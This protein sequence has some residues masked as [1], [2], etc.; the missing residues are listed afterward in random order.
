MND[1]LPGDECKTIDCWMADRIGVWI[2][3]A[4]MSGYIHE[5]YMKYGL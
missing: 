4:C 2:K 5:W 3:P 1:G